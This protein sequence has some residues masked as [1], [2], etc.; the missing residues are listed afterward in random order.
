MSGAEAVAQAQLLEIERELG[1]IRFRLLGA[2][3]SLPPAPAELA[4]HM[5][6]EEMDPSTQIRAVIESVLRDMIEPAMRDLRAAGP[7]R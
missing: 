3:A 1:A 5:E 6:V 4:R 7:A 2:H